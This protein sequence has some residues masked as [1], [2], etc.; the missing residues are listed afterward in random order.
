MQRKVNGVLDRVEE[1][2]GVI[3]VEDFKK[4]YLIPIERLP[5]DVKVGTWFLVELEDDQVSHLVVDEGKTIEQKQIVNAQLERIKKRS[6][7]SKFKRK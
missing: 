1:G 5:N 3:L 4:E 7:G 6:T 2:Y